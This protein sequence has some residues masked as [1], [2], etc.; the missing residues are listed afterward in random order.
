MFNFG[1]LF[2]SNSQREGGNGEFKLGGKVNPILGHLDLFHMVR[3][4]DGRVEVGGH[5][6]LNWY[7]FDSDCTIGVK[8]HK[9][10]FGKERERG[11]SL[12]FA[13]NSTGS[14]SIC[15]E[16]VGLIQTDDN[17][18]SLS[19]GMNFQAGQYPAL[20]LVINC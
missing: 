15:V 13:V 4:G 6:Y 10:P 12:K 17:L 20:G 14:V 8:V 9:F 16:K 2:H 18:V 1:W 7:N 3:M 5:C 19:L 11:P